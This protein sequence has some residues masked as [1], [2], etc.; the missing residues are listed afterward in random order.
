MAKKNQKNHK[1]RQTKANNT[2]QTRLM[3]WTLVIIL[4]A[5]VGI[6]FYNALS[7]PGTKTEQAVNEEV[8]QYDQQPMLG[9]KDAP[10]RMVEFADFKCPS[11]K[12]FD[13]EILPSVKKDFIDQGLVQ[14]YFINYPI[15]TPNGDSRT[16]AIAGEA[17]YNQNPEEFWKFYETLFANQQDEKLN[18]A[19]PDFLVQVAKDANLNIDFD[20][21][22]Q[23]IEQKA[24]EENVRTDMAIGNQVGVNGTPTVFI[25]GKEIAIQD[26]FNYEALKQIILQEK[27]GTQ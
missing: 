26:A 20:K 24:F 23:D 25:N 18:W 6:I 17:V 5:C 13:Q 21:M 11:C 3:T 15:I 9:S 4:V 1:H 19:T 16:A 7:G 8:F 12:A 2:N 10:V 27:D 14:F 22:K